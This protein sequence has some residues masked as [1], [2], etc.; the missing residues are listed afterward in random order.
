MSAQTVKT[1]EQDETLRRAV[2]R[3]FRHGTWNVE[4]VVPG[5]ECV[6][7]AA[8][9]GV[10]KE[11]RLPAAADVTFK[12]FPAGR[13]RSCV[14]ENALKDGDTPV[15]VPAE[16]VGVDPA[17][18]P[19]TFIARA[20]WTPNPEMLSFPPEIVFVP[21]AEGLRTNVSEKVAVATQ[22]VIESSWQPGE[23]LVGDEVRLE[24]RLHGF[25]GDAVTFKVSLEHPE[26]R[27]AMSDGELTGEPDPDRPAE[28]PNRWFVATWKVPTPADIAEAIEGA[29]VEQPTEEERQAEREEQRERARDAG[30]P[31]EV[32]DADLFQAKVYTFVF[33][34]TAGEDEHQ[35]R[36]ESALHASELRFFLSL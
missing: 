6:L 23:A 31:D 3:G 21:V 9:R 20:R 7:T 1:D 33:E 30:V 34:M 18:D 36:D 19:N 17:G 16:A 11:E 29:G 10:R 32:A 15:E 8:F 35:L 4:T 12:L 26:G 27:I 25:T 5:E 22:W 28:G 2:V 13:L 14:P 24:T